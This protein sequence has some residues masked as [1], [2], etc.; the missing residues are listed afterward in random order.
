MKSTLTLLACNHVARISFSHNQ[1]NINAIDYI[2]YMAYPF[3][4][5]R[6]AKLRLAS[7]TYYIYSLIHF[8]LDYQEAWPPL[9]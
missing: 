4:S 2:E 6:V 9:Q 5:T 8:K 3:N 7:I 1:S